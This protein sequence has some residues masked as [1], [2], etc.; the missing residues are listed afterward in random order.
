MSVAVGSKR[1]WE[2]LESRFR[3]FGTAAVLEDTTIAARLPL[4]AGIG[5]TLS[6]IWM[7]TFS[8]VSGEASAGWVAVITGVAYAGST[9]YYFAS[10]RAELAVKVI[11]WAS[12]ANN[13]VNHIV[14][15]GFAWSGMALGWGVLVTT[16]AALFLGR[17]STTLIGATYLAAAILLAFFEVPLR[18]TRVAPSP[19]VSMLFAVNM[20]VVSLVLLVP[21]T[22]LLIEQIAREQARANSLLL[23]VLPEAV[24]VRLKESP[25]VIA[26]EFDECTVLFADIVG[27][28]KHSSEVPPDRLVNEL[29]HVFSRFDDLVRDQGAEKI[30]TIGDG[31]MAVAGAPI[32][33][34]GHVDRICSLALAME[35]EMPDINRALD[36]NFE[37][38]IGINT[39]SVV[40]GVIGAS[41][42]AYDLWGD[43]VNVASRMESQGE[44][45]RIQVTRAVVEGARDSYRFEPAGTLDVRG[46][47]EME[48][49]TL[50]YP[51][52]PV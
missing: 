35:A 45:G 37:L 49:F 33:S 7:A 12:V 6:I 9:T 20:F 30:K 10:G 16:A 26:D 41:R 21:M 13:I 5:A 40:A 44:P 51:D 15:G 14:M 50:A 48:V 39:G 42:F 46:R 18:E 19:E 43:T 8:F 32:P 17:R 3:P 23:N 47:G 1:V 31:Y 2:G 27:F 25:G 38:R 22:T 28:T 52:S 24:A 4:L 11:L 34:S 36:T 29:N